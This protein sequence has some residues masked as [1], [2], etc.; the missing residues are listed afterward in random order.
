MNVLL[1]VY[2]N[3]SYAHVFPQGTAYIAAALR[4]EGH[5]I[6]IYNQDMHHYPD[7]HLT[8]YLD[9][10]EPF[11]VVGLGIIGGYW[12]YRK[13][14]GIS[15]AIEA[16]KHRPMWYILGGHGPSPCPGFFLRKSKADF[17][18][19]GEGEQTTVDLLR[20][21]EQGAHWGRIEG[22]SWMQE[23]RC[24]STDD[25][26]L[27]DVDSLSWPAYDLFPM[28]YYRMTPAPNADKTDFVM[29]VASARGCTFRCNFCY[30]MDTGFRP[31]NAG[32]VVEEIKYL[33]RR[34]GITYIDFSD[35]LLMSSEKRVQELCERFLQMSQPFKWCC[36]GRLNYASL[37]V[38][39]LM[40][41]SGCVFINYGIESFDDVALRRMN[42][43]LTT[44][45]IVK[46]VENTLAA[47]I[48]PGLNM[49]WGNLGENKRTLRQSADFLLKY[50]DTSQLRTIRPVTPYPGS[51]LFTYAMRCGL[52]K[53]VEE[54]YERMHLNSDLLAVNFTD[55]SDGEFHQALMG[56]NC[57]L[58]EAYYRRKSAEMLEITRKLYQNHDISFRGYRHT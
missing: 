47:G 10:N 28:E 55:L 37:D 6:T 54:F 33:Q 1:I 11:D 39:H 8:A 2:D 57:E 31:R 42:K 53:D 51:D 50:A 23:D 44:E 58:I 13:M 21:L 16:A 18:I 40:K 46:G 19:R 15:K 45:Q 34:Y 22:I 9:G 26:A 49:I 56:V 4:K 12:Q 14:L 7:E 17:V 20:M 30:R 52:L 25:R 41:R 43:H 3:G 27:A 24:Y 48:S 36:N 35:E 5:R 38:L 29:S 32:A